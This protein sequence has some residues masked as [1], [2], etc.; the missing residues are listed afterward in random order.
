MYA[1][2][3]VSAELAEQLVAIETGGEDAVH[4][5]RTGVRRLRS[6]LSVYRPAFDREAQRAMRGR[7]TGLGERL[8]RVR[9]AEVRAR[10]LEGLLGAESAPELVDAVEAIAAEAR[11]EHERAHAELLRHLRSRAHRTLL[12][13][14]QRFAAAP[15]LAK[16]GRR[17]PRRVARKGLAKAARRVRRSSG[18]SL[19]QRH[20]TRKAARRLRY[21]A[22]AV[23]DDLGREAVRIAAAAKT[24]QDALGDHRDLVLLARHLRVR[25]DAR[26]LSA[27]AAAG[28]AVLA[29]ECDQRAEGLL[30]GLDEKV[31]AIEAVAGE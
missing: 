31:A 21:A 12:A 16:P 23:V 27:S 4:Q 14:L 6:I 26:R 3:G 13:D 28:I 7:L 18:E 20:E 2:V 30:A 17:H 25:A 9:D 8:G 29:A 11:A 22:E 19:E 24:V 5:A 1:L 15:P 10:D